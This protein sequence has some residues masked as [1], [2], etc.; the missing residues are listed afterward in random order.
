MANPNIVNVTSI[1]GN[2][3]YVVPS[4]TSATTNWTYNGTTALTGLTPAAGT[5]N[6]VTSIV[7]SNTTSSAATATVA[8]A[9]N[10]TFG[11]GTAYNIAYQISVPANT[12][13]IVTDKTTSFYVTE[14]Q[15][16]GVTS[17]TAS[18]LTYTATFE[19]IT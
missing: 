2:T 10:S 1:Y 17:G 7:V 16:V 5:V 9:N 6:R 3:A 18:A 14:N 4:T 11:S 15:S 12:T 8:I 19:A 13:L